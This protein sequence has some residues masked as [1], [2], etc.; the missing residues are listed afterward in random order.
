MLAATPVVPSAGGRRLVA[1]SAEQLLSA[2]E[3][4]A[5]GQ[6]ALLARRDA[7]AE[8]ALREAAALEP[9][10]WTH[11]DALGVSLMRQHKWQEVRL[12][13]HSGPVLAV[14]VYISVHRHDHRWP[15]LCRVQR[16]EIDE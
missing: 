11:T 1:T 12:P 3:L 13:T 15:L 5:K 14:V 16:S 10:E 4:H 8:T 9:E 7:E 6:S 2:A